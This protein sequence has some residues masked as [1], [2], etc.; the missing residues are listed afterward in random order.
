MVLRHVSADLALVGQAA[1]E[2][3]RLRGIGGWRRT[4]L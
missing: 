1:P 2:V 3:R 4:N